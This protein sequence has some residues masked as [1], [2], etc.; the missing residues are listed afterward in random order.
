[1]DEEDV[2]AVIAK[3]VAYARVL[4]ASFEDQNPVVLGSVAHQL[5]KMVSLLH[6][7]LAKGPKPWRNASG[8]RLGRHAIV[9]QHRRT[10]GAGPVGLGPNRSCHFV[11]RQRRG[12]NPCQLE[13][14][15][16][17]QHVA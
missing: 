2:T 13:P 16:R 5:R 4:D 8:G 12:A 15:V 6:E 11:H 17:G 3:L 7:V 1:M 14:S 10:A 9:S